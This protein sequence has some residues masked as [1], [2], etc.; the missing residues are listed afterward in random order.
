MHFTI[1]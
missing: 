1:Q